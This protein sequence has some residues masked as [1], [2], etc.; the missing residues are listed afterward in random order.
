MCIPHCRKVSK[1]IKK[2]I[3][4]ILIIV[5]TP[6]SKS[7]IKMTARSQTMLAGRT[8][9]MMTAVLEASGTI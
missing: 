5:V 7:M 9:M 2:E 6:K 4:S 3:L 1:S 8:M